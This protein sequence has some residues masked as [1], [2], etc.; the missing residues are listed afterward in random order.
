MQDKL[1]TGRRLADRIGLFCTDYW[2]ADGSIREPTEEE[3]RQEDVAY[4]KYLASFDALTT[5][6]MD[7]LEAE[8]DEDDAAI[9]RLE[10]A[11]DNPSRGLP[12]PMRGRPKHAEEALRLAKQKRAKVG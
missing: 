11:W 5:E 10:R 12:V 8:A 4:E 2:N 3:S 6:Q 9:G 7:A 1:S